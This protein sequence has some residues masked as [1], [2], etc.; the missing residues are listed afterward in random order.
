MGRGRPLVLITSIP[1][2]I[3]TTLPG[4]M[5]NATVNQRFGELVAAAGGLPVAADAWSDPAELLARIDALVV[6]GGTD[7]DPARY[8]AQPR[9][10]GQAPDRRRDAFELGLVAA[11]LERGVPVLGVCRGMQLLNVVLGGTLI[12]HLPE[13]TE[14]EHDVHEPYATPVHGLRVERGSG[15]A[16]ALGGTRGAVNSVHHQAV[17]GLGDGLRAVAWAP[18]G[19]VEAIE[20]A[21]GRLR[22]VQWH[23]EFLSGEETAAE[24]G[25]VFTALVAAARSAPAGAAALR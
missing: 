10:G 17:D 7:L 13:V 14:L 12:Q 9:P 6:N 4:R 15:L 1:R 8:G 16:A 22:G 25:A 3:E 11:A 23:P 5:A 24:Q 18:D 20:D 2:E 21:S 19:T